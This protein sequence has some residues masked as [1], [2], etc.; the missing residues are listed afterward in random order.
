[1]PLRYFKQKRL[2][3]L[4]VVTD[5]IV[6][7]Q[8]IL[9]RDTGAA[10]QADNAG[11][12]FLHVAVSKAD[13]ESVLF[14]IGVAADVNSRVEDSQKLSA[15]HLAVLACAPQQPLGGQEVPSDS[16]T[17]ATAVSSEKV[18][19]AEL[20]IRHL[21]LAGADPCATEPAQQKNGAAYGCRGEP[22]GTGAGATGTREHRS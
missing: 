10:E 18:H 13:L 22:G 21:L 9:D 5:E 16:R 8:A 7:W 1:M 11:R 17:T 3:L 4:S 12:S 6:V 15:L 2:L 20:I 19:S 14:L